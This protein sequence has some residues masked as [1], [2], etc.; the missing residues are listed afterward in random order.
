MSTKDAAL[1]NQETVAEDITAKH[2]Y[3]LVRKNDRRGMTYDEKNNL[4][5]DPEYQKQRNL[6]LRSSIL[7]PREVDA[8]GI[9]TKKGKIDPFTGKERIPGRYLIRYY[10]GC[11]TL[12]VDDQPKDKDTIEQLVRS[13]RE[14]FFQSGYLHIYG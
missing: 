11:T 9:P 3:V 1:E 5:P 13:T 8:K 6:L 7:W 10:D 12:F 14:L 4:R 2:T